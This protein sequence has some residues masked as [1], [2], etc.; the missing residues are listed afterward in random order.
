MLSRLVSYLEFAQ[1][2]QV[3]KHVLIHHRRHQDD[4]VKA[5]FGDSSKNGAYA[6]GKAH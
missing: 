4:F 1:Q 2:E 3:A 6:S 5:T